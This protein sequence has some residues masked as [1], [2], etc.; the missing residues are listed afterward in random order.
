MLSMYN[1]TWIDKALFSFK[2]G[3][4]GDLG[5]RG[6]PGPK[7]PMGTLVSF[8]EIE[9]ISTP[10]GFRLNSLHTLSIVIP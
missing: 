9:T 7:G 3:P 6:F 8:I 5:F 2:Q 1:D 10:M 4:N